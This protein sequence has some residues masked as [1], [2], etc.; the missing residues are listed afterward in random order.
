MRSD[1]QHG[2]QQDGQNHQAATLNVS[3]DNG[4]VR[5]QLQRPFWLA[6]V[7]YTSLTISRKIR[8][9]VTHLNAFKEV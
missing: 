1:P 6:A 7:Y 4:S 5:C 8:L 9:L 2:R 3:P